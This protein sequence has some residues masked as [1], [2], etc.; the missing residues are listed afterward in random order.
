[1]V[2]H[3]EEESHAHAPG[4]VTP[5][6]DKD[7][8]GDLAGEL[9]LNIG[10]SLAGFFGS[11]FHVRGLSKFDAMITVV[12]GTTS[13]NYLTPLVVDMMHISDRAQFACAFFIGTLGLRSTELVLSKFRAKPQSKTKTHV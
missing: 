10:F 12:V 3:R 7:T 4:R 2:L 6:V 11:L 1:M 8:A 13:A 9:G 5:L